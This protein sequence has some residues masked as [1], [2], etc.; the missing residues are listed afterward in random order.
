MSDGIVKFVRYELH[1]ISFKR[2]VGFTGDSNLALTVQHQDNKD[3]PEA[4]RVILK[5]Q[6][7][8]AVEAVVVLAG[9]FSL[10]N[11]FHEQY[12]D[13]D[14]SIIA[15][16]LLLPYARSILSFVSASDGNSPVLL[17]TVNLNNLFNASD[18]S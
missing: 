6:I 17:P 3:I 7:T 18:D 13:K 4:K 11:E 5:V 14:L 9:I 2:I 10:E 15:T 16:S 12:K 1:E 8:G